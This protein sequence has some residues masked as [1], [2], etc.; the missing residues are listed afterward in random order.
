MILNTIGMKT[1]ALFLI[2]A[3]SPILLTSQGL[4]GDYILAAEEG[5]II[6]HLEDEGQNR[7]SGS[8]KDTDG[9]LYRIQATIENGE[10]FGTLISRD[11]ALF[12]EA[13]RQ[14]T[15]LVL[16]I[17]PADAYNQ[18]DFLNGK[19]FVLSRREEARPP[20][21]FTRQ[22]SEAVQKDRMLLE[23]ADP[24]L[25]GKWE[26]DY[27]G[28]I[29]GTPSTLSVRQYGNQFSGE[30]DAGGYRYVLE[31]SA[32]GNTSWGDAW[33]PQ[34][35]NRMKF[36][37][38]L[39]GNVAFIT[40]SA[41]QG[42]FEMQFYRKGTK[43]PAKSAPAPAK[44]SGVAGQEISL[45]GSWFFTQPHPSG[46]FGGRRMELLLRADGSYELGDAKAVGNEQQDNVDKGQWKLQ[47]DAL[48]INQ[49]GKWVI[50]AEY[51]SREDVLLRKFS[52][53]RVEEWE[54]G[55]EEAAPP[56]RAQSDPPAARPPADEGL[57][58]S[59]FFKKPP[60]AG[61]FAGKELEL[62]LR[63][64]GAFE[65]GEAEAVGNPAGGRVGKGK[66]KAQGND[67]L[68]DQGKGWKSFA[69][70]QF[71]GDQLLLKFSNGVVEQWRRN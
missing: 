41:A 3:I 63:A 7:L 36:S 50:F 16:T 29:N 47:G 28:E 9:A 10:A 70:Y 31:G 64:D 37:G 13:Y 18:P 30:V 49:R 43:P 6:L 45:A 19:E 68:I 67:L 21:D 2:L 35:D 25:Y 65:Y 23:K 59:W 71:R 38:V 39:N 66:W 69:E 55:S 60:G 62:L 58:G 8:L 26:D 27:Y 34:S 22:P 14:E 61:Q 15:M 42:Q 54:K 56:P 20:I 24:G 4:P 51:Q 32:S 1:T 17:M 46:E 48:L 33:D 57:T 53:G 11:G 44:P 5:E 12:F 52:D 40:L